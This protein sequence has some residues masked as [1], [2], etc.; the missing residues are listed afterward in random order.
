M[1]GANEP[2]Y[3]VKASLERGLDKAIS[4]RNQLHFNG[5]FSVASGCGILAVIYSTAKTNYANSV[6][7]EISKNSILEGRANML[8][9]H[10]GRDLSIVKVASSKNLKRV[11]RNPEISDVILIGPGSIGNMILSNG[12][13]YDWRDVSSDANHLKRGKIVQSI[14]GK[15]QPGSL[16]VPLT[17][18]ALADLTKL[19]APL[20]QVIN[21][22]TPYNDELL[23]QPVYYSNDS[24]IEQIW[25]LNKRYNSVEQ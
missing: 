22:L 11:F 23:K 18:F 8:A 10:Y 17:T 4:R 20:G 1:L 9:D 15:F 14:C 2:R 16:S 5:K 21:N 25:Q 13:N 24:V 6:Q 19:S 12:K 3:E 7:D